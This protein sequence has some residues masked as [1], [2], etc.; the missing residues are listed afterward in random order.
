MK[1]PR[2]PRLVTVAIFTTI[3][4]IFW[5][6]FSLYKVFTSLEPANIDP[7]LLE[8]LNPILDTDALNRLEG[9]VF[10]QEGDVVA[11]LTVPAP[12]PTPIIVAEPL[13]TPTETATDEGEFSTP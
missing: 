9:R 6:F 12:S 13:E 2:A 1:K 3:T 10:F 5:V 8:P 11:P 4:I 7:K